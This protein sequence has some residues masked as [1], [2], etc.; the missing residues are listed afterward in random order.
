MGVSKM[1]KNIF[2]DIIIFVMITITASL[3]L[4]F[5]NSITKEPIALQNE[6]LIQ[7][8]YHSVFKEGKTFKNNQ[9]IDTFVKDFPKI[10]KDKKYDFGENGITI[11]DVLVAYNNNDETIGNVIKVTT[12]DGYGGDITLVV[13]INNENCI[14]GIEVL[15]ID[16]TVGLGMNAKNDSFKSQYYQKEVDSFVITKTGK[17]SDQEIDAISGATITSSAFNNAINGAITCHQE[18]KEAIR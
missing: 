6:Q 15:A 13:G 3:C 1:K 5:V 16:E 17:Q 10:I 9:Q 2:K 12:K 8:S 7:D 14:T 18:I 4:A 11:D